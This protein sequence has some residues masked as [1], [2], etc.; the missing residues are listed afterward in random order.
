MAGAKSSSKIVP[1][2]FTSVFKVLFDMFT[3]TSS[4][5]TA[6]Y[7]HKLLE[8]N[9]GHLIFISSIAAAQSVETIGNSSPV[10]KV[11]LLKTISHLLK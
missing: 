1:T 4:K 8:K 10:N 2:P 7:F 11:K 3:F 9:N 6:K 5:N